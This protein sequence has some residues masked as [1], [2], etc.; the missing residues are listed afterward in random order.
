MIEAQDKREEANT[1][2]KGNAEEY[3]KVKVS[4]TCLTTLLVPI[5]ISPPCVLLYME[6]GVP[7]DTL[8]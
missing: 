1:C 5:R 3:G 8:L 2:L 6:N 7:R 4:V